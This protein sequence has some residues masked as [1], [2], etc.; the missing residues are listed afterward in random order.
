MNKYTTK[1]KLL[2]IL[3][4]LSAIIMAI[5][6]IGLYSLYSKSHIDY[7]K[8]IDYRLVTNDFKIS[9]IAVD[10]IQKAS[11][12]VI[13]QNKE[14][15]MVV[16]FKLSIDESILNDASAVDILKLT[17]S[18]LKPLVYQD[19]YYYVKYTKA[20][21]I[22]LFDQIE[23]LVSRKTDNGME[24]KVEIEAIPA[25]PMAINQKWIDKNYLSLT[26]AKKLNYIR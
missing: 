19:G 21:K 12:Y 11:V 26:N 9:N 17:N 20:D 24:F 22:L 3:F 5:L 4:Y 18:K 25:K 6:L 14:V 15:P 13:N 16:R 1:E 23:W 8:M 10:E 2:S 7:E